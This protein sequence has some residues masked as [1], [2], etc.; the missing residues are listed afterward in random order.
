M[1]DLSRRQ[2]LLSAGLT[3]G[4]LLAFYALA[5]RYRLIEMPVSFSSNKAAYGSLLPV[6]TR[7]TGETLLGLP[8]DFQYTVF[9]ENRNADV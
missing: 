4:G 3:G 5:K 1:S 9:G 2:F 8:K 6:K 7:N